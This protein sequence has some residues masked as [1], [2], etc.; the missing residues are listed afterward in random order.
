MKRYSTF[1]LPICAGL[2]V[3][4]ALVF[5]LFFWRIGSS[6]A[7]VHGS[8][9]A[10][11]RS[12]ITEGRTGAVL[13]TEK[14]AVNEVS[15]SDGMEL[16]AELEVALVDVEGEPLSGAI[17]WEATE[18]A[19]PTGWDRETSTRQQGIHRVEAPLGRARIIVPR[20]QAL[21]LQARA[22]PKGKPVLSCFQSVAPFSGKK[23]LQLVF[24]PIAK[25]LHIFVL[26]NDLQRP[27]AE[28]ML[29]ILRSSLK[30][31][32]SPQPYRELETDAEGYAV[33][34]GLEPGAYSILTPGAIARD[35]PPRAARLIL[36][37]SMPHLETTVVLVNAEPSYRL[38]LK[39]EAFFPN[40]TVQPVGL[41]L[42]RIAE[43]AGETYPVPGTL[44]GKEEI[45]RKNFEVRVPARRYR[46]CMHPGGMADISEYEV[47][48]RS[49]MSHALNLLE[50]QDRVEVHLVGLDRRDLPVTVF[51]LGGPGEE[52]I[53]PGLALP[54]HLPLA[55]ASAKDPS[56]GTS[57]QS[58]CDGRREAG[59]LI[60][61]VGIVSFA[62]RFPLCNCLGPVVISG[63]QRRLIG[64]TSGGIGAYLTIWS[65]RSRASETHAGIKSTL[66]RKAAHNLRVSS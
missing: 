41:Y 31:M 9:E 66:P 13:A 4:L 25:R 64:V 15:T 34:E 1:R 42:L 56:P 46:I 8:N 10:V 21:W 24:S 7:A 29:R 65:N 3:L 58:R 14:R 39:V 26:E 45:V 49:D 6:K 27:A 22:R 40:P 54:G 50:E 12:G 59:I 47:E 28:T 19:L 16:V 33:V 2:G 35:R 11:L 60:F 17:L 62:P 63:D 53:E 37:E 20:G 32:G 55:C 61:G 57:G 44:G 51:P 48:V 52:E 36:P 18:A 23:S 30:V 38:R 43:R 5:S